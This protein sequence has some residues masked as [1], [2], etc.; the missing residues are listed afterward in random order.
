MAGSGKRLV[1]PD[2]LTGATIAFVGEA[3]GSDE[4]KQGKPFVGPAGQVF[5]I[6]LHSAGLIRSQ[7]YIT[8]LIKH[9]VGKNI[10]KYYNERT[11]SLT[12]EG[13]YWRDDLAN[14]LKGVKANIV[15]PMGGP[16]TA[17]LIGDHK[18]NTSRRGYITAATAA[19]NGRKCLPT[20]HP[21]A[22]L[23]SGSYINIHY[24]THDFFKAQLNSDVPEIVY[25]DID[26]VIPI[27]MA[28]V[29]LELNN[30]LR[31]CLCDCVPLGFDIELLNFEVP[32]ISFSTN[33]CRSVCIPLSTRLWTD[34]EETEIWIM[35]ANILEHPLIT[36]IIQNS[37][38]E[39]HQLA[40][41]MGIVVKGSIMD[42][43]VGHHMLYPDFKKSL[44]FL[45]SIHDNIPYW[46]D[47]VK[48]DN[49]KEES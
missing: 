47:M 21:A 46:K 41:R 12:S 34:T 14:E 16:A 15:V 48:F 30:L 1:E 2:G 33:P 39:K 49:K 35:I 27:T 36:K 8:N 17:A 42:T 38:F 40:S 25:R 44:E 5:E 43:M 20:I 13:L 6:C 10:H 29:K 4:V 45:S 9:Q 28:D 19:F 11:H 23:Y 32:C 24:I 31:E 37:I 7:V 22:C 3:P 18:P 26:V